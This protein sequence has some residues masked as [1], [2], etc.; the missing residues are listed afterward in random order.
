[1]GLALALVSAAAGAQQ[2]ITLRVTATVPPRSC[3]YPQ[4]CAPAPLTTISK[5]TVSNEQ[6]RYIGTTPSVTKQDDVLR[7][8]F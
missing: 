1:M 5:V 8:N 7:V 3:E 4:H 6:V 2:S